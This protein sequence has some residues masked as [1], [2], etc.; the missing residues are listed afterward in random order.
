[1]KNKKLLGAIIA[2]FAAVFVI[3]VGVSTVDSSAENGSTTEVNTST[4]VLHGVYNDEGELITTQDENDVV[5]SQNAGKIENVLNSNTASDNK[6]QNNVGSVE[7]TDSV[8]DGINNSNKNYKANLK[9]IPAFSGK[10]YYVIN[11]NVPGL[12]SDNQDVKY[13]EK[14]SPLDSFGRCGVAYACLGKETMPTGERGEIGQVKPSGWKTAKYNCVD[15]KYLFNRCHLIGFQLSGENANNRNLITGTRYMNVE[16]MLPFENMVADYI[17]ETGNHVLYRVTPIFQG[18][19]LV[20]RGVQMEAYSVE[21]NGDGICFNVYCYNNQPSVKIDYATGNS[22][23]VD[24]ET[25]NKTTTEKR[26]EKTTS[27]ETSSNSGSSSQEAKY[28]LNTNSKKIHRPTCS[29][30]KK[31]K[32]SNKQEYTGSKNDLLAQGYTTCGICNP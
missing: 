32:E 26:A 15:G 2:I 14:Y 9:N 1:M 23:L 21:D 10:P 30:A 11:G 3:G 6:N 28:I 22:E 4:T 19:E 13:F 17:K 29:S 25:G 16:G 27:V 24:D 8:I 5:V 18:D 7:V 20:A 31:M 12:K